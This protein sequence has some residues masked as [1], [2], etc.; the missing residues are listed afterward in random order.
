MI[1]NETRILFI[2]GVH[3]TGT[4]TLVGILNCHPEIFM[5]YETD[6]A[7]L[8]IG[9]HGNELLEGYPKARRFFYNTVDIGA[10]YKEFL[11]YLYQLHPNKK[12]YRYFGNKIISFDPEITNRSRSNQYKTIYTMRD[13]RSWLCKE[14]IVRFYRTDLDIVPVA[15]EYLR[16]IIGTY[17]HPDC[18]RIK[19]EDMIE[20]NEEVLSAL[21]SFLDLDIKT[22]ADQ[23][24]SKMGVYSDDDPK[25]LIPW[26]SGGSHSSSRVKPEKLDTSY[27][28]SSNPF[29]EEFLPLFDKYYYRGNLI[30]SDEG[31]I[32]R[33]DC[34]QLQ[35]FIIRY[36]P[37]P[38]G[39]CYREI[40]TQT[41]SSNSTTLSSNSVVPNK[42]NIFFRVLRRLKCVKQAAL[43]RELS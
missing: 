36:S 39:K 14:A 10:P 37:L 40:F 43:G 29:W 15:I 9:K 13:I 38:L 35:D 3:K 34:A 1:N 21:S 24:W 4:S 22:F 27:K 17:K 8:R 18:L 32:D 28:L 42:R 7:K 5:L 2:Q 6:M 11:S 20:R 33:S 26:Y 30:D 41:L 16:F 19:L 12:K 23:W 31:E 25:R